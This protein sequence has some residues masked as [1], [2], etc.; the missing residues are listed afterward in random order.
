MKNIL[1]SGIPAA[2][3]Y[4]NVYNASL[5]PSTVHVSNT[6]L[7]FYF[8]RYLLQK[9]LS[10]FEFENIPKHWS[11]SYFEYTLFIFGFCAVVRTDKYGVIPQH[12][13][14]YGYNVFYQ[15]TN[16]IISNP[17]LKGILQ[18]K[19]GSECGL[20]KMQP[21]YGSCWDIVSHYADLMALSIEALGVNL[22]NSKLA[23]VF[24]C[25]SKTAAESFKK[26]YD[27][28][29]SGETASFVDKNL[30]DENGDPRWMSFNQNLKQNYIAD[31][32]LQDLAKLDSRF[33][34]DVGIPNVNIAKKSGVS[35]NE[36]A[37]NNIDTKAKASLWLETIREGLEETNR[38]FGLDISVKLR[39]NES[40][41]VMSDDVIGN[42]ML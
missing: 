1:Q 16:A 31:E 8:Q 20:I 24:A 42:R 25:E 17:L 12:C 3:D 5:Q 40:M 27:Q 32:I 37:S 39:F 10:V 13:G 29:A 9:I 2:Y 41:G 26:M 22:V 34:T 36:I 23:Y 35:D 7:S 15:P 4:M 6:G 21:D 28:I 18:P 14:L 33:N 38:L 30:F 19:I 11:K